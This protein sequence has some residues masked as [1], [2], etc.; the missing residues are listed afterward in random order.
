MSLETTP[1]WL[2]GIIFCNWYVERL[3]ISNFTRTALVTEYWQG[4]MSDLINFLDRIRQSTVF[5]PPH[6]EFRKYTGVA[7]WYYSLQLISGQVEYIKPH[8]NCL[9]HLVLA[10]NDVRFDKLTSLD[11]YESTVFCLNHYEFRN[12]TGVAWWY[13]LLQLVCGEVQYIKL[14]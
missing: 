8:L 4:M 10:R 12:Y 6:Y 9:D 13:Y 14:H 5:C 2:E 11:P 1:E 3:S 7:W